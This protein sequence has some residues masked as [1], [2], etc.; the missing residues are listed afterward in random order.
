MHRARTVSVESSPLDAQARCFRRPPISLTGEESGTRIAEQQY[1]WP[2]YYRGTNRYAD[3]GAPT[4]GTASEP[5]LSKGSPRLPTSRRDLQLTTAGHRVNRLW[6]LVL[7]TARKVPRRGAGSFSAHEHDLGE[8][9]SRPGAASDSGR[10][11][12]FAGAAYAFRDI[13]AKTRAR[14]MGAEFA[15]QFVSQAEAGLVVR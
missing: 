3:R 1:T 9:I 10:I 4:T 11:G 8:R 14:A 7:N 2:H 15:T 13:I 12:H 6:P 5:I